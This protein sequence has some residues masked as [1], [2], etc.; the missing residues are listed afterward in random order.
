M[1][2]PIPKE[3]LNV[4][5]GAQD[6][7]TFKTSATS[8]PVGVSEV[9]I[10]TD[11]ILWVATTNAKLATAATGIEGQRVTVPGGATFLTL[12]WGKNTE[13]HF[14]NISGA[15]INRIQIIGLV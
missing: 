10:L 3:F 8:K 6:S 13:L 1:A 15:L 2:L 9:A 5:I 11:G 12:P 7:V 4:A 14:E